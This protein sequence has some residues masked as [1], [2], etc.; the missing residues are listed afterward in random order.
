MPLYHNLIILQSFE[1]Y[2]AQVMRRIP[3][4]PAANCGAGTCGK[5]R[6][7][8]GCSRL[9][10]NRDG[11]CRTRVLYAQHRMHGQLRHVDRRPASV[12]ALS[13][14]AKGW[15]Y[16]WRRAALSRVGLLGDAQVAVPVSWIKQGFQPL[17]FLWV[18][19]L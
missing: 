19:V 16:G 18:S 2:Y 10:R 13:C 6:N 1:S 8:D 9:V 7:L 3:G 11:L 15:F 17:D 5:I 4:F 14:N 12:A